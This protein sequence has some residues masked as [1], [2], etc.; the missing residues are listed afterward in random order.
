MGIT[1]LILFPFYVAVFYFIFKSFRNNYTDPVLKFYHAHGFWIKTLLVLVF[2]LFNWKLSKGDSFVLYQ[3][4][5]Y[6]IY[7][8]I[9][10]DFSNVKWILMKGANF[11][12]SL[13]KDPWNRGYLLGEANFMVVRFVTVISFL[14][15]GKYLL[16]NLVFSLLA[17][18]GAWKLFLFFY[19][20]YPHMHRKFAI[21]IIYLPTF[22]FWSSGIL[23]DSICVGSIGW[24]T[25]S[26]YQIFIRKKDFIKN[27]IL[28]ILFGYLLWILK[29][30][31]LISYV[32]FFMLYLVL[33]N[34]S[35]L[36]NKA[37]KLVL[38]PL[39]IIGCIVAFSQIMTGLQEEMGQ[40]AVGSITKNVKNMNEA[41]ENQTNEGS[42][43]FTYGT[44]FDGSVTG[45]IKMA[46]IF[47]GTTFFRPFIWES[48]KISTVLSSLEGL[49]FMIFTVMI[50]FTAGFKTIFQTLTKN[51]LALYCFLF[52]IIFSLF[53]G[54]TTLNFGSLCRYK[55]PCTPFYLIAL[56][57]I[58]DAAKQK[59]ENLLKNKQ[60]VTV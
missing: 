59:K 42:S 60:V 39:L 27:S 47:I 20:Q 37:V 34:V 40:Y 53:V 15:F 46:P 22:I 1:E 28:L 10:K 8:L 48:K 31:I 54:A 55:I 24:I 12:E 51:P 4:E 44:E 2:T 32:P 43:M 18:T 11:D 17:F 25:Y 57:L 36:N 45:L 29:P 26:L 13:L 52:S 41:Y 50:F 38:A 33:K 58:Q 16:T 6:N 56:F 21:A 23:K 5:G 30:Y 9:L 35:F 49:V 19:E 3:T 14:T 7:H